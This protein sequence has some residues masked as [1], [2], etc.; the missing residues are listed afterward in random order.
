[1]TLFEMFVANFKKFDWIIFV[2]GLVNVVFMIQTLK[3]SHKLYKIMHP[4][5]WVPGGARTLSEIEHQFKKQSDE[6]S[7][8]Q[9]VVLRRKTNIFFSFYENIT[10]IFPLMGMLGTVISLI[11]MVGAMGSQATG[12]FFTA[13]TSTFWGII[14]AIIFKGFNGYIAAQIEDN[15][16]NM[17]IFLNR[18]TSRINKKRKYKNDVSDEEY[19]NTDGVSQEEDD[20]EITETMAVD[21]N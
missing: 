19:T 10:T 1:M 3:L 8:A 21:N 14:F 11:P 16:K 6:I 9:L 12:Y 15:E 7:E 2:L 4:D 5:V 17:E 18:N 20:D 13:L